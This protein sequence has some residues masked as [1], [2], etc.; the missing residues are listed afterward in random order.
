MNV[1]KRIFSFSLFFLVALSFFPERLNVFGHMMDYWLRAI[2]EA[3]TFFILVIYSDAPVTEG[4]MA[5]FFVGGLILL[6]VW[7][8]FSSP[9]RDHSSAFLVDT[10]LNP[11]DDD[12]EELSYHYREEDVVAHFL[13]IYRAQLGG[14]VDVPIRFDPLGPSLTV[15]G[16]MYELGVMVDGQWHTREMTIGPLGGATAPHRFVW[17]VI[18]DGCIVVKIPPNPVT[19]YAVYSQALTDRHSLAERLL[20][21]ASAVPHV[22]VMMNLFIPTK[23]A[24]LSPSEIELAHMG[25]LSLDHMDQK[26]LMICDSFAFFMDVS[27]AYFLRQVIHDIHP[28]SPLTEADRAAHRRMMQGIVA[29]LL[30]LLADLGERFVAIRDINPDTLFISGNLEHSPLSIA[31]APGVHMGVIDVERAACLVPGAKATMGQPLL[32]GDPLYI[33]PSAL[34]SN[35]VIQRHLG[36][37]ARIFKLQDWYATMALIFKVVTGR[38]LFEA[39]A[40]LISEASLTLTAAGDHPEPGL[41]ARLTRLYFEKAAGE[42]ADKLSEYATALSDSHMVLSPDHRMGLKGEVD[43]CRKGLETYIARFV[44]GQAFFLGEKSGRAL[45]YATAAQVAGLILTWEKREGKSHGEGRRIMAAIRFLQ[46]LYGHKVRYERVALFALSLNEEHPPIS[47][48]ALIRAMFD[49][50]FYSMYTRVR[51]ERDEA[52]DPLCSLS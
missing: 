49:T 44:E 50:V 17:F 28:F 7:A 16:R 21:V 47:A 51:D 38:D 8:V 26:Y 32:G 42:L 35:A 23:N 18:Y 52:P 15:G 41:Y 10:L 29:P 30:E 2:A 11:A 3:I 25:R 48:D 5:L 14:G 1:F 27:S 45:K 39:S 22:T 34:F 33:T 13:D 43:F 4:G 40:P 19:D 12:E 24:S 31:D 46:A 20:P 36:D 9:Q 37:V 6:P